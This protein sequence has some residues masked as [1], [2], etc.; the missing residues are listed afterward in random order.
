MGVKKHNHITHARKELHWLPIEAR[1]KF[2]IITLTWKAL[3]KMGLTYIK[4]LLKIKM[5][6]PDLRPNKV[7]Y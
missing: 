6:R 4:N 5:C 3:N 2:K 1:C 7:V